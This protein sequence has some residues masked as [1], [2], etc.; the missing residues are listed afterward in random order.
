MSKHQNRYD[1]QVKW[2]LKQ[3]RDR[4]DEK[5]AGDG[6]AECGGVLEAAQFLHTAS[7]R[8]DALRDLGAYYERADEAIARATA[9]RNE[10]AKSAM[11]AE[12]AAIE[13]SDAAED[14]RIAADVVKSLN[15][16][17]E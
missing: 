10:W 15:E 14:L 1:K 12:Q 2:N 17:G 5:L 9:A 8:A 16:S 6:Y 13:L 4:I 3:L 11:D 7:I